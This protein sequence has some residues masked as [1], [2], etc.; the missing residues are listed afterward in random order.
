MRKRRKIKN[1]RSR[2]QG[3]ERKVNIEKK[4]CIIKGTESKKIRLIIF[5]R[6][7]AVGLL[8]T[9]VGYGIYGFLI[10][11]DIPY[12]FAL[13]IA[14]ILGVI[15][16]Y[17]SIGRFVFK[18][19]GGSFL[20]VKFISSYVLVYSIN[21]IALDILVN[22]FYFNQYLGQ[23]AFVPLNVCISWFLMNYWVFKKEKNDR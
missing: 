22:R 2:W 10:F 19:Q 14:T 7:I 6:F 16:N 1:N 4:R 17:F 12:L 13:L 20:F 9:I 11:L 18:P 23:L 3:S 8:N 15:F 21:A 5:S